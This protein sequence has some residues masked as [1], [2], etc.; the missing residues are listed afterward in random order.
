MSPPRLWTVSAGYLCPD[1]ALKP[2]SGRRAAPSHD[3]LPCPNIRRLVMAAD[4]IDLPGTARL[5]SRKW[6]EGFWAC[7]RPSAMRALP[8]SRRSHNS[9]PARPPARWRQVS[10]P[11]MTC[12]HSGG[13]RCAGSSPFTSYKRRRTHPAA[14]PLELCVYLLLMP[15]SSTTRHRGQCKV[16]GRKLHHLLVQKGPANA[17][18]RARRAIHSARSFRRCPNQT[19]PR[20]CARPRRRP[21][22]AGRARRFVG[23]LDYE[24]FRDNQLV[25]YE[26][27]PRHAF[28]LPL[29]PIASPQAGQNEAVARISARRKTAEQNDSVRPSAY[30]R[31]CQPNLGESLCRFL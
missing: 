12:R 15:C 4:L 9:P 31:R 19:G 23:G 10:S 11:P 17:S 30:P 14:R 1:N 6:A 5:S 24:G 28:A 8:S 22:N 29:T 25:F 21:A 18:R 2:Y 7:P 27:N 26:R 16:A 13:P 20:R 3:Q